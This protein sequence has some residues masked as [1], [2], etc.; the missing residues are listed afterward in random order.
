MDYIALTKEEVM[1]SPGASAINNSINCTVL[2][3]INDNKLENTE[4]LSAILTTDLTV[5]LI[6]SLNIS[7]TI[8]IIEDPYDC[9]KCTASIVMPFIM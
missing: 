4:V 7:T 5:I 8:F 2:T 6:P 3:I 1:F 9:K